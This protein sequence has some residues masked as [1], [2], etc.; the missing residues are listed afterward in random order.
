MKPLDRIII[1]IGLLDLAY[2]AWVA[3]GVVNGAGAT[4]V[5]QSVVAFGLPLPS[6]QVGGIL[7]LYVFITVCGLALVLRRVALAWL[8]YVLFPLRVLLVLP[9]LFPLVAVIAAK[10]SSIAFV[11]LALTE[12]IR[13]VLVYRWSHPSAAKTEPARAAA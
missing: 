7:T 2:V 11:L 13:V 6:I 8:N 10:S 1:A 4:A 12:L 3:V 9:T 5:W